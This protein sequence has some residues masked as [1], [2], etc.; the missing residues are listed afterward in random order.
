[1]RRGG[2]VVSGNLR[3][4]SAS[5]DNTINGLT[6]IRF[7]CLL[8]VLEQVNRERKSRSRD[9]DKYLNIVIVPLPLRFMMRPQF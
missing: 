2:V 9:S 3:S 6:D 4:R 7:F 1:M 5:H 8:D